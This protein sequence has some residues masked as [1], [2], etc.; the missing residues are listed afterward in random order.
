MV[1]DWMDSSQDQKQA[2]KSILTTYNSHFTQ[3]SS[4]CSEGGKIIKHVQIGKEKVKLFA[5]DMIM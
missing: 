3:G 4:Q 2:K 1:N 5:H